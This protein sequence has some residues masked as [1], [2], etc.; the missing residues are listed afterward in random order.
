MI[1]Y[2]SIRRVFLLADG[3]VSPEAE[4]VC[5]HVNNE[6]AGVRGW[7]DV[8]R[9]NGQYAHGF[10]IELA[11]H[12]AARSL[13]VHAVYDEI[14]RLEGT[15]PRPTMTKKARQMHGTLRGLWHKHFFDPRFMLRNLMDET[16]QMEK[17]GRWEAM[18]APHYGKYVHEIIDE[19]SYKAV[20]GAYERRARDRRITGEF[21]VYERQPDG[22]HYYLTLATHSELRAPNRGSSIRARVDEYKNIDAAAV[23]G[24]STVSRPESRGD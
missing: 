11:L 8:K 13:H 17:D 15:D 22:S 9:G 19:V 24:G 14:G 4:A 20:V 16:E 23:C 7:L 10:L 5:A 21:I 3:A 12:S 1:Q 18:F 6:I 2:D